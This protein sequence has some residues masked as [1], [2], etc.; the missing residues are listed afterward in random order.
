MYALKCL[1][2]LVP[3]SVPV[4]GD[5][6]MKSHSPCPQG[7]TIWMGDRHFT[8][9]IIKQCGLCSERDTHTVAMATAGGRSGR[10]LGWGKLS[11]GPSDI[12]FIKVISK[13]LPPYVRLKHMKLLTS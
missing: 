1:C 4:A 13:Q 8:R 2:L 10:P 9:K 7:A 5:T 3:G 11:G 12:F 6:Q